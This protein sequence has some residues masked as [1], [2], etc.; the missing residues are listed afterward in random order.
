MAITDGHG[1]GVTVTATNAGMGRLQLDT[2]GGDDNVIVDL[3]ARDLITVPITFDGGANSDLLTV[4]ALPN[5]VRLRPPTLLGPAAWR[6][7]FSARR[8]SHHDHRHLESGTDHRSCSGQLDRQWHQ[9]R[10]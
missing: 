5:Q 3:T 7:T 6:R 9:H 1:T 10:Q 2:R 8:R 4:Q